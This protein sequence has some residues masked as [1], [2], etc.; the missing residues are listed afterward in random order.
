MAVKTV[1][2]YECADHGG[3]ASRTIWPDSTA[4][5]LSVVLGGPISGSLDSRKKP[6]ADMA[7]TRGTITPANVDLRLR[8]AT[9]GTVSV[10]SA[11]LPRMQLPL[12][13]P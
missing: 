10:G 6:A 8:M 13:S 9:G 3:G 12:K 1:R 4:E 2:V 7:E 11:S 5:V